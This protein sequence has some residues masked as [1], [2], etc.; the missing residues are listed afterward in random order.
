[1]NL[2][3]PLCDPWPQLSISCAKNFSL[4]NRRVHAFNGWSLWLYSKRSRLRLI[5]WSNS[6]FLFDFSFT[7]TEFTEYKNESKFVETEKQARSWG[8]RAGEGGSAP[9]IISYQ[10]YKRPW[11]TLKIAM[12]FLK[13]KT[14]SQDIFAVVPMLICVWQTTI[15]VWLSLLIVRKLIFLCL[16]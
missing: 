15:L 11:F 12:P 8:V 4:V 2:S 7:F 16:G 1:M 9:E 5:V 6:Q 13:K 10:S 3:W 14:I